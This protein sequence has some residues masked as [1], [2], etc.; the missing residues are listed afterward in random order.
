MIDVLVWCARPGQWKAF[1]PT[2][3]IATSA[4]SRSEALRQLRRSTHDEL[5]SWG[6]E[7]TI[8][9]WPPSKENNDRE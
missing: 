6:R 2:A 7:L 9:E 3:G 5:D 4:S 1:A 8:I